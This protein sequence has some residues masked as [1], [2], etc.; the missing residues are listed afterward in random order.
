MPVH[1]VDSSVRA[2][3][4][5]VLA[6][7]DFRAYYESKVK[8]LRINGGPQAMGLCPFHDDHTPSLSVNL[9]TGV[10]NRFGCE[11]QGDVFSFRGQV[12]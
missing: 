7:M 10:W 8:N 4:D 3:R 1:G 5:D 12:E 11:A 6:K 2:N 9:E